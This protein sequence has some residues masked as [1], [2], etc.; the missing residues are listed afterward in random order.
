[1]IKFSFII[2]MTNFISHVP[3]LFVVPVNQIPLLPPSIGSPR[4]SRRFRHFAIQ[5]QPD[6]PHPIAVA[7][8]WMYI[9]LARYLITHRLNF[10]VRSP[11]VPD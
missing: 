7:R 2:I 4:P 1:M 10:D 3:L 5:A 6:P 11:V 8:Q 9:I